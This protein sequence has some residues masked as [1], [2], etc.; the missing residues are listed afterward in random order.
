MD[1]SSDKRT[2]IVVLGV[3][4]YERQWKIVKNILQKKKK[5]LNKWQE[6]RFTNSGYELNKLFISIKKK[7]KNHIN[8]E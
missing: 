2:K 3:N 8:C 7:N 1:Y 4:Q 5:Q 6:E